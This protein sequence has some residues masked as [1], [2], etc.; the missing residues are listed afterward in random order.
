MFGWMDVQEISNMKLAHRLVLD[1]R[2][3]EL[4][5]HAILMVGVAS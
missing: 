4:K 2:M 1:I 5:L 3:L